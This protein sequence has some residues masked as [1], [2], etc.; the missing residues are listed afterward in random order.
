MD[1]SI[2]EDTRIVS[3][4]ATLQIY[5]SSDAHVFNF[6]DCPL[7]DPYNVMYIAIDWAAS[8]DRNRLRSLQ[9]IH[10]RCERSCFIG[11]GYV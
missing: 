11:P 8:T 3:F 4:N 2:L 7:D 10:I 5:V 9:L 6:A 1:T